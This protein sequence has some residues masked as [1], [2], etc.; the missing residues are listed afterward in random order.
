[1]ILADSEIEQAV[2]A[3]DL[4]IRRVDPSGDLGPQLRS[5]D[6]RPRLTTSALDLGFGYSLYEYRSLVEILSGEPRGVVRDFKVDPFVEQFD[7]RELIRSYGRAV[8]PEADGSFI[9][10]PG[11]FV[12]GETQEW[13]DLRPT[14]QIAARVEG[15]STLA[16]LGLVVHLTAPTIHA[17]FYGQIVL[18]ISNF[19]PYPIVV[20]PENASVSSF[21]NAWGHRR[22]Q[23]R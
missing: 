20:H 7:I 17:S 18:E 23:H 4:V 1:M 3:G 2:D 19:G 16:R 13:V 5:G 12:L 8:T 22:A 14:G 11:Q 21:S 6:I 10:P 15:R 9:I